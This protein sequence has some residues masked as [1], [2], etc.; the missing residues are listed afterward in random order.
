MATEVL[1]RDHGLWSVMTAEIAI[2]NRIDGGGSVSVNGSE[3]EPEPTCCYSMDMKLVQV[4]ACVSRLMIS[5]LEDKAH[6]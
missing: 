6:S 5:F 2:L 3:A 1:L 4:A